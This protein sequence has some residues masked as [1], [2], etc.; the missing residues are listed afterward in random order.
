MKVPQGKPTAVILS[1]T[2]SA[3]R[4]VAC[5]PR[6]LC[7]GDPAGGP[8][9]AA[10]GLSFTRFFFPLFKPVLGVGSDPAI[11]Q[12]GFQG[13]RVAGGDSRNPTQHVGQVRPHVHAIASGTLDQRV[14][15]RR[16]LAA[17]HF[18]RT[19]SSCRSPRA[20]EAVQ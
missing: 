18:R 6:L 19:S 17:P 15:R 2:C 13:S 12:Q 5:F 7:D 3:G 9:P 8:F 1:E 16:R 10:T 11:R 14:Q 20:A 4:G